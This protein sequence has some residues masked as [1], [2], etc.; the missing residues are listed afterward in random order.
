MTQ[1]RNFITA[2]FAMS[3][4]FALKEPTQRPVPVLLRRPSANAGSASRETY[5]AAADATP[6]AASSTRPWPLARPG[7]AGNLGRRRGGSCVT[8]RAHLGR[9]RRGMPGRGSAGLPRRRRRGPDRLL[10]IHRS[11]RACR[12]RE[13]R[14]RCPARRGT[15]GPRAAREEAPPARR[16]EMRTR[17]ARG[18][19][20]GEA[21]PG[22][23]AR[24][25][26]PPA[27]RVDSGE[28]V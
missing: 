6:A 12:P 24:E 28:G 22:R 27:L 14:K 9:A 23:A 26:A 10:R 4:F 5:P 21:T 2:T 16:G 3:G 8:G 25:E 7:C 17:S 11:T 19:I 15:K 18:M 1:C 20:R 13:V